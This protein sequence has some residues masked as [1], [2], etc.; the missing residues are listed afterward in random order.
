MNRLLAHALMNIGDV[1][2]LKSC[3]GCIS[4]IYNQS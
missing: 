1:T 4:E 2:M 3:E